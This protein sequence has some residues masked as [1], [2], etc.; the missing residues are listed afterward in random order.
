M[1]RM[2]DLVNRLIEKRGGR[3]AAYRSRNFQVLEM[4]REEHERITRPWLGGFVLFWLGHPDRQDDVSHGDYAKYQGKNND[5]HSHQQGIHIEV[6]CPPARH[7][8]QFLFLDL[9]NRFFI[10]SATPKFLPQL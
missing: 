3:T 5:Q 7:A 6:F 9:G 2:V 10:M 4:N 1:R 8:E